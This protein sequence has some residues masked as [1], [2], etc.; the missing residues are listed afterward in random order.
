MEETEFILSNGE[1]VPTPTP[2]T[3][4]NEGTLLDEIITQK[5]KIVGKDRLNIAEIHNTE[6]APLDFVF[7]GLKDKTVGFISSA[8]GT[9]K[10]ML[11]LH[12]AFSLADTTKTY[13]FEP[14][15]T[16]DIKRGRVTYLS[17]ED[18][19]DVLE[20]RIKAI[21]Q[22]IMLEYKNYN[23]IQEIN[24]NLD[25]YALYGEKDFT[26]AKFSS[27]KTIE[28]ITEI[29]EILL[30]IAGT[31]RLVIIDTFRRIHDTDENNN[32]HMSEVLKVFE[33][34]CNITGTSFLLLHHQNKSAINEKSNNQTAMRGAS[35][36]V[37]NARLV[38]N[39]NTLSEKEA[40]DNGIHKDQRKEYV[41]VNYAKVNYAKHINDFV[42]ARLGKGILELWTPKKSNS[43]EKKGNNTGTEKKE[44]LDELKLYDEEDL[45]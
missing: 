7:N 43:E 37:D 35:A 6:L 40:E 13:N 41:K 14:I 38:I 27:E 44:K 20:Y 9:G 19:E 26:L 15:I 24:K 36:L 21:T 16:K 8:G 3:E 12:L 25:I 10:S 17:L 39:L 11:A 18:P 1:V 28:I 4:A 32:G 5:N 34:I 45:F 42:L 33:N 29:Y 2:P 23:I 22:Y 31:S 30:N